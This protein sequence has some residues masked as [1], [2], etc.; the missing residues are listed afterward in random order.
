M[1]YKYLKM[2]M[3]KNSSHM[4]GGKLYLVL[5]MI[6]ASMVVISCKKNNSSPQRYVQ[7]VLVADTAGYG[8]ARIDTNL[9]NP[10][11][12][13][14]GPTGLPWLSVN[15]TGLSLIY[16]VN[17]S[18]VR[19]PVTVDD[20]APTGVIYNGTASFVIP[21]TGQA[22]AFIFVTEDGFVEAWNSK[23]ADTTVTVADRSSADAIY[24]GVAMAT[25]GGNNYLYAADFHNAKVDVFDQGFNY[26]GSKTLSDPGIP[27]GFAP[28]N[29]QNIDGQLYVTYAMQKGPDNED[30]Q[31]GP[32]NG[33]VD[34]YKPDGSLVK[35][36]ASQG[37][38]NSPW[39][40]A[41]APTGFGQ[42]DA[43]LIGNFGDGRINIFSTGGNY[44]GQLQNDNAPITI[45]GLWDIV[46]P[47]TGNGVDPNKLYFTA[48]PQEEEFGV[49]GY[50]QKK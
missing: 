29:I 5:L 34:I 1:I 47:G 32:G 45:D 6:T 35:R 49:F 24:K 4:Q 36:F 39:G 11:G 3:M 7:T 22:A 46:F 44:V 10:W 20:A 15:H 21:G 25:D 28:F 19:T 50:I 17:G 18:N 27:A 30:D 43:I 9:G 26:V 40:V 41:K 38:L 37:T 31:R 42:G 23:T 13:A 33:Y 8:A 16:D 14:F 2:S 12:I 48:G